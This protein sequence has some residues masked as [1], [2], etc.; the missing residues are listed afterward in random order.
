MRIAV[1]YTGK[2]LLNFK[3][4][5]GIS[6]FKKL[7]KMKLATSDKIVYLTKCVSVG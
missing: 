3:N 2:K 6:V 1:L 4:K 7:K 5:F